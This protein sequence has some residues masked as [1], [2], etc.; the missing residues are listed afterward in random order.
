MRALDLRGSGDA[1]A[2]QTQVVREHGLGLWLT[3]LTAA[4][5]NAMRMEQPRLA[6]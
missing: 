3:T 6:A 2:L 4:A 5:R 1:L